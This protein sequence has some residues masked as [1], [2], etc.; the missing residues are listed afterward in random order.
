MT[1]LTA[2]CADKLEHAVQTRTAIARLSEDHPDLTVEQGYLVQQ[3]CTRR[4]VAAGDPVI[5]AKLG[6]TAK[7]K[8]EQMKVSQPVYGV[9]FATGLHPCEEPL[10]S[11]DLISPR[12]EPEIVFRLGGTLRGP[13]VSASEV[14]AAT[15]SVCCGLEVID[16]RYRDFSFTAAD[17][18][19]DNTSQAR[20]VLGPRMVDPRGVDLRL[21]GLV[22]ERDGE[23]VASAAGAAT[24]GH[25]AEAVALLANW[26]GERGQALEGGSLVFSGGL[27]AAVG[28]PAGTFVT[29]TFAH[30]GSVTVRAI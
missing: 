1:D 6:L 23:F 13:G 3:E 28:L 27:T 25:P 8:Q 17:V 9:L 18:V 12:V 15:E 4:R 24:V 26:L 5:G 16:S 22:L 29:A 7:A 14:I 20:V 2:A 19:A 21:L 30:L 11:E 10:R